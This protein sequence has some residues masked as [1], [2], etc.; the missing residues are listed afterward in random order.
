MTPIFI[1]HNFVD[2]LFG[3]SVLL[4]IVDI[5]SKMNLL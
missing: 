4:T 5:V 3:L 2:R 1:W